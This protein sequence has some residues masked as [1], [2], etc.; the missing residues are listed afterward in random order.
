MYWYR[1]LFLLFL[2]TPAFAIEGYIV[3]VGAESDTDD[4]L[5]GIIAGDFGF[6]EQTWVSASISKNTVDVPSNLNLD[7]SSV[8]AGLDHWF[9]PI[10]VRV[11]LASWGD[12]EILDSDDVSGSLYW[13]NEKVSVSADYEFR[14]FNFNIPG[15]DFFLPRTV[16]FDA[17]GIG[18]S[19]R[20]KLGDSVSLSLSGIDYDYSVNLGLASNRDAIVFL[21]SS[22]RLS[23]INSLIDYRAGFGLALDVG[24]SNWSL[25][26]SQRKG[27]VDG[28]ITRSTTLRF[29]TPMGKSND[30]EFGLGFDD[31]DTYGSATFFSVFLYFYGGG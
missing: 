2:A 13:R 17:N 23:I 4:G 3:G 9:K 28:S 27:A 15:S 18:L 29:L 19:T 25:D 14:D 20:F 31:S 6:T 10:G 12:T 30:I 11:G 1:A 24:S 26:Y 8:S 22:S 16:R 21:L 5:S 7:T